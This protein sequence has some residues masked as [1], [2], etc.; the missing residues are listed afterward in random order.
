MGEW[1]QEEVKGRFRVRGLKPGL[2]AVLFLSTS[3]F[4]HLQN[5]NKNSTPFFGILGR[6]YELVFV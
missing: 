2:L 3:Y 5:E 1:S 6:L 4:P